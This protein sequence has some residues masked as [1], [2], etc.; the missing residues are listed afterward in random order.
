MNVGAEDREDRASESFLVLSPSCCMD[1]LLLECLS[2]GL[3]AKTLEANPGRGLDTRRVWTMKK[4]V[5]KDVEHECETLN[6]HSPPA[7]RPA[8][9]RARKGERLGA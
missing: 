5:R 2:W 7:L 3:T 8:C 1:P 6:L 9:F 4:S